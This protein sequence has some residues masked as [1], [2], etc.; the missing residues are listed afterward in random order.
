MEHVEFAKICLG[1][2][3]HGVGDNGVGMPPETRLRA[4]SLACEYLRLVA[5][6]TGPDEGEAAYLL[7]LNT[8]DH[9]E[10]ISM[11]A[12]AAALNWPEA[13][14]AV[15]AGAADPDDDEKI[16]RLVEKYKWEF[17]QDGD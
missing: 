17:R 4:I 7:S 12:R 13:V 3:D 5:T 15:A 6:Q 14:G 2:A 1:K 9:A 8:T 10:E 11:L 16:R